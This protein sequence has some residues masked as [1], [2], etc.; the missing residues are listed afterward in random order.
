[1]FLFTQ[2]TKKVPL[3]I[4]YEYSALDYVLTHFAIN[5][6]FPYKVV[7]F[8]DIINQFNHICSQTPSE[9]IDEIIALINICSKYF[10]DNVIENAF[11]ILKIYEEIKEYYYE[12]PTITGS[13]KLLKNI[14]AIIDEFESSVSLTYA[15]YRS[16]IL[17]LIAQKYEIF[18]VG[19]LLKKKFF[20]YHLISLY[21]DFSLY[22]EIQKT[23][24]TNLSYY[25]IEGV[26]NEKQAISFYKKMYLNL[27]V[28]YPKSNILFA[29]F[30]NIVITLLNCYIYDMEIRSLFY[31]NIFDLKFIDEIKK[32]A[33]DIKNFANLFQYLVPEMQTEEMKKLFNEVG[34]I[35]DKIFQSNL[36]QYLYFIIEYFL[37]RKHYHMFDFSVYYLNSLAFLKDKVVLV[38]DSTINA[39]N[40]NYLSN[41]IRLSLKLIT[42]LEQEKIMNF[43]FINLIKNNK[44]IFISRN[45]NAFFLLLK[46][47]KPMSIECFL[48]Y[49][50][51]YRLLYL[52]VIYD[53]IPEEEFFLSNIQSVSFTALSLL[54]DRLYD[55]YLL[56][57]LK[58]K[59]SSVIENSASAFGIALHRLFDLY[60][61]DY[62][63]FKTE[64]DKVSFCK[65]NFHYFHY[66]EDEDEFIQSWILFDEKRRQK[67]KSIYTEKYLEGEIQN[68]KLYGFID[69][70]EFDIND[71]II[72]LDFKTGSVPTNKSIENGLDLQ[73]LSQAYVIS[74][75]YNQLPNEVAYIK[76]ATEYPYFEIKKIKLSYKN[77]INLENT[78][79]VLSQDYLNY[80]LIQYF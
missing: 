23:D 77:F 21:K 35:I 14:N 17:F 64:K 30:G 1:M 49:D 34:V 45:F 68:V 7:F 76:V 12:F 18:E 63:K 47:T 43:S 5:K 48:D 28:V 70:L 10:Q 72:L 78:I 71:E 6:V 31:L 69:R 16:Q 33:K 42:D 46:N 66:F 8:N 73:L 20:S 65:D 58:C 59:K 25:K 80:N 29:K 15:N 11:D 13:G 27:Y 54:H 3:I 41:E 39:K 67:T 44:V 26:F 40:L 61:K 36:T 60:N 62:S 79:K 24:F 37:S 74:K 57:V 56:H 51:V 32:I 53:K 4:L 52:C 55:F 75:I 50:Q 19:I 9:K 22:E 2:K 38:F